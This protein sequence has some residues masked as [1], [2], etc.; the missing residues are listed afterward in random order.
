MAAA[1]SGFAEQLEALLMRELRRQGVAEP[2]DWGEKLRTYCSYVYASADDGTRGTTASDR[3]S[4]ATAVLMVMDMTNLS[5]GDRPVVALCEALLKVEAATQRG[6]HGG[7]D[8]WHVLWR[9]CG[10]TDRV[11]RHLELL[12]LGC[13]RLSR[14]DVSANAFTEE[15][16]ASL[17]HAAAEVPCDVLVGD[18]D[19]RRTQSGSRPRENSVPASSRSA[20]LSVEPVSHERRPPDLPPSHSRG[21]AIAGSHPRGRRSSS[22]GRTSSCISPSLRSHGSGSAAALLQRRRSL[23]GSG[24]GDDPASP[25]AVAV[26][27]AATVAAVASS[28]S[29]SSSAAATGS[30]PTPTAVAAAAASLTRSPA[31]APIAAASV[32]AA[33]APPPPP[34]PRVEAGERSDTHVDAAAA[35]EPFVDCNDNI[36][37]TA[38]LSPMLDS[39]VDL[40]ALTHR[41]GALRQTH[42]FGGASTVWDVLEAYESAA[43]Q[44][45]QQQHGGEG[46]VDA[47]TLARLPAALLG[48]G[49]VFTAIT[50]LNLSRNHL[51][52]LDALPAT[53]LR[54][55]VSVNE[56][57]EL[58]GLESCRMLAVLNARRNRLRSISGLHKTRSVA[59]LFLGHNAITAVDGVAHLVLLETLDLTFN[60]IRTHASLRMLSLC[61][62]LRHV[63]LRGN[64]VAETG[65]PGLVAVLRNLCPTLLLVDDH[66]LA[67]SRLADRALAQRQQS[68]QPSSIHAAQPYA[69]TESTRGGESADGSAASSIAFTASRRRD[70]GRPAP[71]AAGADHRSEESAAVED[72]QQSMALLRLLTRGVTAPTGYGDAARSRHAAQQLAQTQRQQTQAERERRV[73]ASGRPLRHAVVQQLAEESRQ[74][75]ADTIVRRSTAAQQQQQHGDSAPTRVAEGAAAARQRPLSAAAETSARRAAEADLLRPYELRVPRQRRGPSA[76]AVVTRGRHGARGAAAATPSPGGT[77]VE[78]HGG[79]DDTGGGGGGSYAALHRAEQSSPPRVREASDIECSPIAKDAQARLLT[80]LNTTDSSLPRAH[81]DPARNTQLAPP[82]PPAAAVDETA[83]YRS[84]RPRSRSPRGGLTQPPPPRPQRAPLR[85]AAPGPTRTRSA[86]PAAAASRVARSRSG[87]AS[88]SAAVPVRLSD[89]ALQPLHVDAA[90]RTRVSAWTRQLRDDTAALQDALQTLVDLLVSQRQPHL[91][92]PESSRELPPTYLH[93]RRR[94]V[95]IVQDSGMLHDTHVPMDVVVFYGFSKAELDGELDRSADVVVRP[96]SSSSGGGGGGG[97]A[98]AQQ[99][100]QQ[101]QHQ[102]WAREVAERTDVL[103]HIRLMGDAKT[104]LRYVALLVGDG[105]ERLLQQYADQLKESL[106]S[107]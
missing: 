79:E 12:L 5:L 67:N 33:A 95:Q 71:F 49:G 101:Q 14:L 99:Q 20:S 22:L 26:A 8:E 23:F 19:A 15:G 61:A 83:I 44:Q 93:E 47:A 54:L 3:H 35:R 57:V 34:A 78:E 87:S 64:P 31:T 55:D 90:Q 17:L 91:P 13:P 69:R 96:T 88:G 89:S 46:S 11:L 48:G 10:L 103:R 6:R 38:N 24:G 77:A 25:A 68:G 100:Q 1:H 56:L 9:R 21:A 36:D 82:P 41:S 59:H 32:A 107:N 85:S 86:S 28:S 63:L 2:H 52:S 105:R 60:A 50:V 42:M 16:Q 80:S 39:V 51:T 53:L 75:V 18:K 98:A 58:N 37:M 65:K 30:Q 94:C 102:A 73:A 97:G 27:P 70:G 92:L 40:S 84:S 4:G 74:Y 66:R 43:A 45:Q 72:A 29:A 76:A 81:A 104:C 7:V 106:C 62:A